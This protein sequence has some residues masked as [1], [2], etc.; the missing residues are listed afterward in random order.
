MR[1]E[2]AGA[3]NGRCGHAHGTILADMEL[4][5]RS[6]AFVSQFVRGTGIGSRPA[7]DGPDGGWRSVAPSVWQ[8]VGVTLNT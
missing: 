4:D 8:S 2:K 1:R 3:G 5:G 7:V 6:P